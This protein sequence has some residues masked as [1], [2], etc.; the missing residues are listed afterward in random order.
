M[1]LYHIAPRFL[2]ALHFS[3]F[4]SSDIGDSFNGTVPALVTNTIVQELSFNGGLWKRTLAEHGCLT[5]RV[6]R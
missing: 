2:T 3:D 1:L 4:G 5:L 6:G